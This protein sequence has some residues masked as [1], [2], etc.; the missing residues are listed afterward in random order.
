VSLEDSRLGLD[1]SGLVSNANYNVK[2]AVFLLFI[3]SPS[4]HCVFSTVVVST[5]YPTIISAE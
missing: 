1:V 2:R 3:N 5:D 4:S